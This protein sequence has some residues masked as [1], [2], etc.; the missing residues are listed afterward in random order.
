MT[1]TNA[2]ALPMVDVPRLS[3]DALHALCVLIAIVWNDSD[4]WRR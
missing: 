2:A 1:E 3:L 4:G